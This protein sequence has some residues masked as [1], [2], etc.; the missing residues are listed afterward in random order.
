M[1]IIDNRYFPNTVDFGDIPNGAPFIYHI[2]GSI[3][4]M[5]FKTEVVYNKN[6]DALNVVSLKDGSHHNLSDHNR[7]ISLENSTF[8]MNDL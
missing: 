4:L 1:K 5:G 7:V 3:S 8:T 2:P 6:G